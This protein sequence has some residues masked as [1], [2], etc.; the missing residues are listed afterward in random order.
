M[1]TWKSK[2]RLLL[3]LWLIAS[4]L[5]CSPSSARGSG[6][7]S[8]PP[9]GPTP[10]FTIAPVVEPP[11]NTST[12]CEGLSGE[13]EVQVLAGPAAAVGLEPFAVGNI[14]FM[15]V[16]GGEPYM[17]EG[18]GPVAYGD[19]LT[20]EWGTYEVTLN[21]DIEIVGMCEGDAGGEQL[22]IEL[23][24]AGD[25]MVEVKAEGFH[26][27]YPWSGTVSFDLSFPVSDGGVFEGDGWAF[28]IHPHGQ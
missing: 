2:L 20:E 11:S 27:T 9:V 10:T 5:A 8:E 4:T 12:L 6:Q 23:I 14:P 3:T 19:V 22:N 24:M 17:V 21:L 16:G 7:D 26:G 18:G 28:I 25:Q 1:Y 13:I 15:V